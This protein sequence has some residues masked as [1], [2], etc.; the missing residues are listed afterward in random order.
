MNA[1]PGRLFFRACGD[2]VRFPS[3]STLRMACIVAGV[4]S[5][6]T[7][8]DYASSGRAKVVRELQ[9]L[10]TDLITISPRQS[11]GI[12]GRARTGRIV[13]TL[14]ERDLHR[15]EKGLPGVVAAAALYSANFPAKA[16]DSNKAALTVVGCSPEYFAMRRWRA[17]SGM[18]FNREDERRLS[19]V[20][21]V[22][23]T[24]AKDL[25]GDEQPVGRAVYINRVRFE[26]TGVLEER[27]QG[28]DV[29]SEDE[30]AFVPLAT[31][32]KRLSNADY[33]TGIVLQVREG[34]MT[35]ALSEAGAKMGLLH[36]PNE[37]RPVDFQV[38]S[39]E[40]ILAAE[41]AAD[42]RLG[43]IVQMAGAGCLLLL[44]SGSLCIAW[45]TV[46]HRMPEWGLLRL[47][48]ASRSDVLVQISIEFS[49]IALAGCV[50]GLAVGVGASRILALKTGMNP[51]LEK[52]A[53]AIAFLEA[54]ALN[55][56]FAVIPALRAAA[57]DPIDVLR[58]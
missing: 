54:M 35:Q 30:E 37:K 57:L 14:V 33:F 56:G 34:L 39:A 29:A 7:S 9:E 5:V 42:E 44:A 46:T 49:L 18:L 31:A 25:F 8:V 51:V 26:V 1:A 17:A 55:T 24:L 58:I 12:A 19:R 45:L 13:T 41:K 6:I 28:R 36:R 52:Q 40:A 48:G 2:I 21:V 27:G 23:F 11:L 32:M 20:V 4:A 16:G 38:Q 47:I 50:L 43:F 15:L 10:G 53:I 22:G 3:Q